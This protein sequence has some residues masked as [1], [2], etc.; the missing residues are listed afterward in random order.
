MQRLKDSLQKERV[1]RSNIEK[2]VF[3]QV[4]NII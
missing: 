3:K 1:N 4:I 2:I